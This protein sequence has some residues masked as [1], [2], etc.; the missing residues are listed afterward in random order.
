[1]L[2]ELGLYLEL[3]SYTVLHCILTL[4]KYLVNAK[5]ICSSLCLGEEHYS[6]YCSPLSNLSHIIDVIDAPRDVFRGWAS[7]QGLLATRGIH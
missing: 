7:L 3:V 1:M 2:K 6:R 4:S 5:F